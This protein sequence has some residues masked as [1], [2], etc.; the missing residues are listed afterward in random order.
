MHAPPPSVVLPLLPAVWHT[1]DH[2]VPA[3]S[4]SVGGDEGTLLLRHAVIGWGWG[5][6]PPAEQEELLVGQ[7]VVWCWS[8]AL[9]V[10]LGLC[11]L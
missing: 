5:W 7:S 9:A 2:Q 8:S 6:A 4:L 3:H 11:S 10:C 1:S